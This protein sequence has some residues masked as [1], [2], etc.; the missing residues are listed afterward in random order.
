VPPVGGASIDCPGGDPVAAVNL[1]DDYAGIGERPFDRRCM[2]DGFAGLGLER[3]DQRSY[4]AR[5]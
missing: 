5:R 4:A 2:G 3:L 1:L